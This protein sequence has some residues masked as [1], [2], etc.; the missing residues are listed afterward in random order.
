[1]AHGHKFAKLKPAN[2][3]NFA[4]RQ[5]SPLQNYPLYGTLYICI[6]VPIMKD[7]CITIEKQ[8]YF[9]HY[10]HIIYMYLQISMVKYFH[11]FLIITKTNIQFSLKLQKF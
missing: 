8:I 10:T 7:S 4:I 9:Y 3:Q 1:M 5:I 2:H 6:C 11:D